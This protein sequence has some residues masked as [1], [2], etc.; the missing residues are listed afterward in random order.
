MDHLNMSFDHLTAAYD[1]IWHQGLWLKRLRTVPDK[2]LV[3][4]IMETLSNRRFVLRTSDGQK[5]IARPLKNGVPQ[6]SILAPCLFN[7]YI[8]DIPSTLS[9]KL[10]YADDLAL[11]FTRPDWADV[12]NARNRDLTTLHTYYHQNRFQLSKEKTV[13]ALYHLNTHDVG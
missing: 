9:I 13:H 11:A 12:Q 8:S 1:M 10:A 7:I 5:T 6:G 2:H 3:A 4:F